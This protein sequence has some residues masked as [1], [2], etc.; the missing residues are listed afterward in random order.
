VSCNPICNG[1]DQDAI[2]YRIRYIPLIA[3]AILYKVRGI[4][5]LLVTIVCIMVALGVFMATADPDLP[6]LARNRVMLII[7]VL[8]TA[9]C[10]NLAWQAANRLRAA[11]HR[12]DA[13][14]RAKAEVLTTLSHE[15]RAPLLSLLGLINL[16]TLNA[17]PDQLPALSQVRAATA[18]LLFMIDSLLDPH[19]TRHGSADPSEIGPPTP[20]VHPADAP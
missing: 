13:A 19:L 5:W 4:L 17:R 3:S 20:A 16:M 14:S 7:A 18:R 6:H 10:V 11:I 15:M 9:V 12:A 1:P 2:A 8:A